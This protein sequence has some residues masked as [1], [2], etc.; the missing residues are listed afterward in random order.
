MLNLNSHTRLSLY[1]SSSPSSLCVGCSLAVSWALWRRWM[2][3]IVSKVLISCC[4]LLPWGHHIP[5]TSWL[6]IRIHGITFNITSDRRRWWYQRNWTGLRTHLSVMMVKKWL[7]I[8][9][10]K[11]WHWTLTS[12]SWKHVQLSILIFKWRHS[13]WQN[14]ITRIW[15]TLI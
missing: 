6:G 9:W 7:S 10:W 1:L 15:Y 13:R 2:V 3:S 14:S 8:E 11:I 4:I 12:W 5:W